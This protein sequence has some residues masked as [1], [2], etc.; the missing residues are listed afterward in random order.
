MTGIC[1]R[2]EVLDRL[3]PMNLIVD[4][5]GRIVSVGPTLA[6][7]A[8]GA[9]GRQFDE[10]FVIR[11]PANTGDL[12]ALA[13]RGGERLR[14]LL[15]DQPDITLRGTL[16]GAQDGKLV[17]NLSFGIG[18]IDAV[19]RYGLT[20]ADFAATDLTVEMLYLVE[21][22]AAVMAELKKLNERLHGAKVLAEEQALT[23]TLTGLR[24]RRALDAAMEG[25]L[26]SGTPFGLM[27]VDLDYVYDKDPAQ[28]K[29]NIAQGIYM[30]PEQRVA[31]IMSAP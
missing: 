16:V 1:L 17:F 19:R 7:A 3:M 28:Q 12:A 22:K 26:S 9:V 8:T 10:V 2:P 14:L 30:Q 5:I 21:A 18:L 29:R 13:Q 23:D 24:N 4:E 11:R 15:R 31:K 6:K 25:L 27:H 20:D